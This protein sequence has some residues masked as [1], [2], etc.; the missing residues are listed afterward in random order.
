MLKKMVIGLGLILALFMIYVAFQPA[1]FRIAR[2]AKIEAPAEIL[3]TYVNDVQKFESWNPWLKADPEVK[4]TFEGPVSGVG[5]ACAWSGNKN[6]GVGKMTIVESL[7]YSRVLMRLD[8]QEPFQSTNQAEFTLKEEGNTTVITWTLM[9]H[10]A[11][12]HRLITTLFVN[13]EKL[14]STTFDQGLA[15][16]KKMAEAEAKDMQIFNTA[17]ESLEEM[18]TE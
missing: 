6:V 11:Y 7:P 2:E 14:V 9:G 5:A 1:D 18:V 10:S 12:F 3:F 8:Y 4:R 17:P 13:M 15:E 16:L